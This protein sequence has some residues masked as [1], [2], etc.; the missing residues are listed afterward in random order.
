MPGPRC[1]DRS[2]QCPA[3]RAGYQALFEQAAARLEALGG[4]RVPINFAPMAEVARLLY[5]SAF[6]AERYSGIRSFLEAPYVRLEV[7]LLGRD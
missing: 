4:Q 7:A 1:R 3:G 5:E 6:I 2:R